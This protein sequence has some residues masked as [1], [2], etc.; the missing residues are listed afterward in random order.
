MYSYELTVIMRNRDL[1]ALKTKV[2]DILQKHGAVIT[3]DA[4]W[5][6]KRMA[7]EIEGERDGYYD[8]FR[9]D[10]P[11]NAVQKII[12]EFRLNADILRYMF[13]KVEKKTA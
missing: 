9:L 8:F 3:E 4:P 6:S 1:D 12:A 5:G 13:V 7:Y 2:R 10:A 11:G